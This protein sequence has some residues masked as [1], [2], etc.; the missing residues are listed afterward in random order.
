VLPF[1]INTK[2]VVSYIRL[3]KPKCFVKDAEIIQVLA[4]PLFKSS[5]FHL[6]YVY[7]SLID[8]SKLLSLQLDIDDEKSN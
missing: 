4:L 6:F 8:I 5:N 1:E 3:V 2:N 7:Q